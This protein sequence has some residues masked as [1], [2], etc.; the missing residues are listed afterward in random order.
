MSGQ[1]AMFKPSRSGLST[2]KRDWADRSASPEIFYQWEPTQRPAQARTQQIATETAL[3]PQQKRL[4]HIQEAL[5][6]RICPPP[7]PLAESSSQSKR[8]SP[9]D[10]P[11]TAPPQKRRRLPPGW[12]DSLSM[13]SLSAQ[14]KSSAKRASSS[15]TI[16]ATPPEPKAIAPIFLSQEQTRILQLVSSGE[17][18][19]YTG[20]A[21]PLV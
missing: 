2:V 7:P 21:G 1:S 16:G 13:P 12:D 10:V 6:G 3:T 14:S 4:K 20:S 17:S 11:A 8:G 5:A 19:F 15:K 9:T 18:V